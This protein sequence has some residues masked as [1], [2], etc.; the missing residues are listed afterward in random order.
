ML[1]LFFLRHGNTF[2]DGEPS[3]QVG[4][5]TDIPLTAKGRVQAEKA[6][7]WFR[8]HGIAPVM[9]YSGGL[10]RQKET[11]EIVSQAL[12]APATEVFELAEL[13]YGAWENLTIDELKE[14]FP[15]SYEAWSEAGEWPAEFEGAYEDVRRRLM[16]F[17]DRVRC[18]HEDGSA[19]VAVTSQGIMKLLTSVT[20]PERWAAMQSRR[21]I[22][23]LKVKTGALCECVFEDGC[24]KT[25]AWNVVPE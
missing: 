24:W 18:S 1:H 16:R 3:R 10:K 23:E 11:A 13:A 4:A 8:T 15:A 22:G 5:K 19:I 9:V 6:A 21:A 2:E 14:K 7:A 12:G 20:E 25:V 17:L